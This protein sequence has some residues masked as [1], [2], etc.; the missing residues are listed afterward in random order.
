MTQLTKE[1]ERVLAKWKRRAHRQAEAEL[2]NLRLEYAQQTELLRRRIAELE[3][4]AEVARES[5]KAIDRV[6]V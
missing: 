4:E 5:R 1:E 2:F 3:S 6:L